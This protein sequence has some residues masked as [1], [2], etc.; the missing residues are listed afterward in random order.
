VCV[1]GAA[2]AQPLGIDGVYQGERVW[3]DGMWFYIAGILHPAILAPEIDSSVLIGF[4]AAARYLAYT[5]VYHRHRA[6]GTPTDIYLRAQTNHVNV[7]D[8]VLAATANP[9]NP[10]EVTISQPSDALV[11]E[12]DAKG[13]RGAPD[14]EGVRGREVVPV[15]PG[16]L[17]QQRDR[18]VAKM[19]PPSRPTAR[20]ACD[21]E[22]F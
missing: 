9:E 15:A 22:S 21:S 8:N 6:L 17:D 14:I 1:L 4:P 2:A 3:A 10:S 7:V 20:L 13:A 11:A 5:S 19:P 12:A 18:R 16:G